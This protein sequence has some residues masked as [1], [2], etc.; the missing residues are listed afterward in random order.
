VIRCQELLVL[1]PGFQCPE[2][3]LFRLFNDAAAVVQMIDKEF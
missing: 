2:L 1:L 3:R